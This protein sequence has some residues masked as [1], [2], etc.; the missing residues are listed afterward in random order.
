MLE[1]S[2]V[3]GDFL[4]RGL[5][6]LNLNPNFLHRR[7]TGIFKKPNIFSK[8]IQVA[9]NLISSIFIKFVFQIN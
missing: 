7:K 3:G 1:K 9:S 6:N 4:L 2:I 8:N 5:G